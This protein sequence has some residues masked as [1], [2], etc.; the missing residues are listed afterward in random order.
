MGIRDWRLAIGDSGIWD[1]GLLSDSG[2]GTIAVVLFC[3][4]ENKEE[5]M[6]GEAAMKVAEVN[7]GEVE[8]LGADGWRMVLPPVAEGYANAQV[9]DY[10][11]RVRPDFPWQRGTRVSLAARFSHGSEQ[12]V[13]TAGF[14]FWNAPFGPGSGLLPA[15]PQATWFFHA[16]DASDLPLA[17]PGE[18]GCGW[19]ASTVDVTSGRALAWAPLAPL[20]LLLNQIPAVH[21]RLWPVVQ[22]SLGISFQRVEVD[23]TAWHSYTLSWLDNGCFFQ[24]DGEPVLQTPFRP[25]GPLGFVTWID[26][27]YMRARAS[28]RF[29][30][31]TLPTEKGQWLEIREMALAGR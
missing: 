27:Q 21:Q 19:F 18:A 23:M 11:G 10:G 5:A 14:G 1:W 7:G 8:R 26:N 4:K 25:G 29:A 15:L 31:G 20:V 12:L 28:G 16:S 3:R 24:V 9:D 30:W 22:R 2:A 13:G 17:P 6:A